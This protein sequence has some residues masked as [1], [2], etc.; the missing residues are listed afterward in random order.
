MNTS[1][2]EAASNYPSAN[3]NVESNL[4]FEVGVLKVLGK[5]LMTSVGSELGQN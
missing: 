1:L 5:V 2:C 3:A 4:L